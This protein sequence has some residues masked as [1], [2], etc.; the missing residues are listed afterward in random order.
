[1]STSLDHDQQVDLS[2][3]FLVPDAARALTWLHDEKI[4]GQASSGSGSS[5]GPGSG[6][7]TD[8]TFSFASTSILSQRTIEYSLLLVAH[9]ELEVRV[10]A[11]VTY[12]AQKSRYAIVAGGAVKVMVVVDRG[13]NAKHDRFSTYTSTNTKTI[14]GLLTKVNGLP[15]AL[16]PGMMCPVDMGASITLRFYRAGATTPY[17]VVVSDSGG[18][19]PV[20][21]DSYDAL[22]A[23][24]G[25]AHVSGGV[26]LS[27]FVAKTFDI[28]SLVTY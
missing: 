19:G 15:P 6:N 25:S 27:E 21:I 8:L 5:S 2:K 11:L 3:F 13:L 16:S 23:L 28:K 14:D 24:M 4:D 7:E 17:A 1:M 22:D 26:G 12:L 10:D 18:C 20:A 9:D